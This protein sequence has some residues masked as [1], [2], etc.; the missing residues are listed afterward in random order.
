MRRKKK[1]EYRGEKGEERKGDKNKK[2]KKINDE[3]TRRR[4]GGRCRGRLKFI[5]EKG[6]QRYKVRKG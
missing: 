1:G 4:K 2:E 6:N 3:V 5:K